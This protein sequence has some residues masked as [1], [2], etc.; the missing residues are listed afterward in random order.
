MPFVKKKKGKCGLGGHLVI[1]LHPRGVAADYRFKEL[2]NQLL[3]Y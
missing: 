2:L 1:V 3:K